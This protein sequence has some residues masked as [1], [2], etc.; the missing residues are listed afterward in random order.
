M[1]EVVVGWLGALGTCFGSLVGRVLVLQVE[2]CWTAL[3]LGSEVVYG[4]NVV[5]M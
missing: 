2:G 4:A 3:G 1:C 5:C